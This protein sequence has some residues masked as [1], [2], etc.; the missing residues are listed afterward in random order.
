MQ[1]KVALMP[2]REASADQI[3]K[4]RAF[5]RSLCTKLRFVWRIGLSTAVALGYIVAIFS[6]S[7]SYYSFL[8]K[9]VQLSNA[10]ARIDLVYSLSESFHR[11]V[12]PGLT[13]YLEHCSTTPRTP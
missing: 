10:T 12:S 1:A 6:T 4:E 7:G 2:E 5:T 13:L 11:F 9:I 8:Y 3:H